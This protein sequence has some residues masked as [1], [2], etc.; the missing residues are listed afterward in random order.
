MTD[1]EFTVE[2]REWYFSNNIMNETKLLGTFTFAQPNDEKKTI[3]DIKIFITQKSIFEVQNPIFPCFLQ[4]CQNSRRKNV[5]CHPYNDNVLLDKTP[6]NKDTPI[7][8]CIPLGG[9]NYTCE[10]LKTHEVLANMVKDLKKHKDYSKK[11]IEKKLNEMKNKLNYNTNYFNYFMEQLGN[12]RE[13]GRRREEHLMYIIYQKNKEKEMIS[14]EIQNVKIK[15][16]DLL[17]KK[18]YILTIFIILYLL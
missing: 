4:I 9:K 13:Y 15:S 17:E 5:E 6:F 1:K 3:K 11:E 8:V 10:N 2:L 16:K 7:K 14:K 18:N 12:E